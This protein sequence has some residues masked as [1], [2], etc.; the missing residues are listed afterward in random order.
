MAEI[1]I[2]T[3]GWH[4]D[5]WR[6]PFYPAEVKPKAFLGHYAGRFS[7]TEVNNSFYRLPSTKALESWRDGTPENF[8]FA[9]KCSRVVT[10]YKRLKDVSENIAFI[11]GRMDALADKF[12]PVL[13][14]LPPRLQADRERLA[15]FLAILPADRRHTLEFRHPSWFEPPILDLLTEHDVSLCLSDHAAAPAPWA[16]T[17]S[18]VYIRPHGPGGRY[19][20]NYSPEALASWARDIA[21]WRREGRDVYCYFDND[22][23]SAAPA[24]AQALAAALEAA[25]SPALTA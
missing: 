19:A 4:Y 21:R 8:L 22:Q 23:K 10:H 15:A 17:A 12:G 9:W 6:G 24:D 16:L 13:F 14:Q 2:G 11:F 5:S 18:W 1:R 25:S 3:S 7:T 20:G